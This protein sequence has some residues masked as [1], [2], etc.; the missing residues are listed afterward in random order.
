M[1]CHPAG[2]RADNNKKEQPFATYSRI[3]SKK[4]LAISWIFF[5]EYV[6]KTYEKTN[7]YTLGYP[8][9]SASGGNGIGR[10]GLF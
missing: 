8:E 2:E 7:P 5:R 10:S 6:M 3:V 9:H 1:K 4:Q